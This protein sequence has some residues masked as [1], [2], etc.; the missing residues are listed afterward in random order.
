VW[1]VALLGI[2]LFSDKKLKF[3][4]FCFFIV[5]DVTKPIISVIRMDYHVKLTSLLLLQYVC[6]IFLVI[7]LRFRESL[8]NFEYFEILDEL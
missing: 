3:I 2:Q 5:H 4:Q 1:Q 7:L 6:D 8:N